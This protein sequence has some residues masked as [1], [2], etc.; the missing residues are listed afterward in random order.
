MLVINFARQ[1]ID[2]KVNEYMHQVILYV[3]VPHQKIQGLHIL[4][5]NLSSFVITVDKPTRGLSIFTQIVYFCI[6]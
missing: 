6:C 5:I 2:G 1:V 3:I 4:W